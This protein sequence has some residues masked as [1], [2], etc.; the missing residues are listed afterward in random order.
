MR[1]AA[2]SQ[3]KLC[4]LLQDK[5]CPVKR[6]NQIERKWIAVV[7]NMSIIGD[8]DSVPVH[9]PAEILSTDRASARRAAS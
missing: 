8:K 2:P 1:M 3:A 7:S 5:R 4:E 9:R 6:P